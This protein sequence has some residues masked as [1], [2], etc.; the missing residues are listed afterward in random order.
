MN[1]ENN[2]ECPKWETCKYGE[3]LPWRNKPNKCCGYI[4]YTGQSRGCDIKD[5]DKYKPRAKKRTHKDWCGS[6]G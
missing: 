2:Y 3:N 1:K 5:C 4:L 6:I